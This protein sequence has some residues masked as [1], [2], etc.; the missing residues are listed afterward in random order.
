MIFK[1]TQRDLPS[2]LVKDKKR[3][4]ADSFEKLNSQSLRSIHRPSSLSPKM[5]SF[6]RLEET[7]L[8]H[9]AVSWGGGGGIQRE[10]LFQGQLAS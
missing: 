7:A 10:R 5:S 1:R 9:V 3:G 8:V 2:V 4:S 6:C